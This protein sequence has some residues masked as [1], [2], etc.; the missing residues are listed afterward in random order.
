MSNINPTRMELMKQKNRLKLASH[1]HKLLKDK[2]DEMIRVFMNLL[3]E[4]KEERK[5]LDKQF[6]NLL[7]SFIV[8]K[9]SSYPEDIGAIELI[10]YK[11]CVISADIVYKVGIRMFDYKVDFQNISEGIDYNFLNI[12]FGMS[13]IFN[14]TESILVHLMKLVSLETNL[15][16]LGDEIEKTRRRVNALEYRM[17]PDSIKTIKFISNKIDENDRE[18]LVRI[19]KVKDNIKDR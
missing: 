9:S 19:I 17:I 3:N 5:V 1:G 4:I 13:K 6:M 7:E 14:F 10:P 11:K 8:E 12:S 2:L 15:T 16:I 18:A